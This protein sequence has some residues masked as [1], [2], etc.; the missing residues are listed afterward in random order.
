MVHVKFVR[1]SFTDGVAGITAYD[2]HRTAK[3]C[4]PPLVQPILPANATNS[5]SEPLD[6][7]SQL[8]GSPLSDQPP[9]LRFSMGNRY[10]A[11]PNGHDHQ[12][13]RR[14]AAHVRRVSVD[15]TSGEPL[16]ARTARDPLTENPPGP[17]P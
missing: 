1:L 17:L 9:R 5:S 4:Q 8:T 7:G 2:R 10:V 14:S 12:H 3:D 13:T 15:S 6:P 16:T 11:G